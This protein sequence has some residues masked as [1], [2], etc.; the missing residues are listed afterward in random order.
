[1]WTPEKE[2]EIDAI[3]ADVVFDGDDQDADEQPE[4]SEKPKKSKKELRIALIKERAARLRAKKEELENKKHHK[5]PKKGGKM[6]QYIRGTL[7]KSIYAYFDKVGIDNV[8]YEDTETLA[9]SIK[10][11]TKFN[12]YH[13][14]WYRNDYK[15]RRDIP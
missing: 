5:H 12:K 3:E 4:E 9:K 1:M 10:K 8:N 6:S 15:N 7:I 2:R 11:D 13:Y 14:S